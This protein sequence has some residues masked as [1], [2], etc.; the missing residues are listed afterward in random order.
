MVRAALPQ[1]TAIKNRTPLLYTVCVNGGPRGRAR[2]ESTPMLFL[3]DNARF[4]SEYTDVTEG[5]SVSPAVTG[6]DAFPFG[7]EGL[8]PVN[9]ER[10]KKGGVKTVYAFP[11]AEGEIDAETPL[12]RELTEA[13]NFVNDLLGEAGVQANYG[14]GSIGAVWGGIPEQGY[15]FTRVE[16]V[17][18]SAADAAPYHLRIETAA[19]PNEPESLSAVIEYDADG[20]VRHVLMSERDGEG[21]VRRA[22]AAVDFSTGDVRVRQV[23]ETGT[24]GETRELYWRF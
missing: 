7:V 14:F 18:S 24:D 20:Y 16:E 11:F 21:V 4:G 12:G 5:R 19:A 23:T 8:L 15:C 1:K 9:T 13:V 10:R 22:T 2:E 17:P 6:G 3:G